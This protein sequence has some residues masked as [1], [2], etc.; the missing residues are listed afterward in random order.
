MAGFL[1]PT[2]AYLLGNITDFKAKMD[3]AQVISG[4][5]DAKMAG[6][7]A[8]AKMGLLAL[9][10]AV[11]GITYEAVK[12]GTSFQ[13][14]MA[15]LTTQAG[16]PQAQIG[17]LSAGVLQL[18]GQVG[19]GPTSLAEALF[20]IESSFAS[21]G[22]TGP[23][24]LNLL[25]IAAEGAAVGHANLVDVTNAL[26]S[27]VVSGIPGVQDLTQA[28]GVLNATVGAGDMTMQD[29]ADAFSTGLLATVKG[30]GLTITDVGAALA[31]FGDNNIRGAVAATELRM[32]VQAMAVPAST[33]A[34][35]LKELGLSSTTLAKDMQSGGLLKALEDL[36]AHMDAA[37]VSTKEQGLILTD[38]FGKKAGTGINVLYDQLG[39][40]Q[41]KYPDL[42]KSA[43]NFG[44]AWAKTK[45]TFSQAMKSAGATVESLLTQL[46]LRLLPVLTR[47]AEWFVTSVGWLRQHKTVLR[48]LASRSGRCWS[49]RCGVSCR[50]RGLSPRRCSRTRF[51]WWWRVSRPW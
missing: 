45:D 2:V 51:S 40:L 36:K 3:E 7:G 35:T 20:H 28:M 6:M 8:G 11:A 39:R 27:A 49:L 1:P 41:S 17:A 46:G 29:L 14:Q 15:L 32:A 47:V 10:T 5:T 44:D 42:V 43:N 50:R 19:F 16:V 21:V 26:D 38:I 22:I 34:K 9:G 30:Y 4:E 25:K 18:A 31:T 12:L 48:P 33:G 23:Q 37:G 13:A 24:A